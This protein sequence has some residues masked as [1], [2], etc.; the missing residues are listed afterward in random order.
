MAQNAAELGAEFDAQV[1]Y[2][3]YVAVA[4]RIAAGARDAGVELVRTEQ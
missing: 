2:K 3:A 4:E 1:H